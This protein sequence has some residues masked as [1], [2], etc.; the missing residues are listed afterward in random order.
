MS[1]IPKRLFIWLIAAVL[2][3]GIGNQTWGNGFAYHGISTQALLDGLRH[4]HS[5]NRA[6]AARTLGIRQEKAAV[7][8]LL[9]RL[10]DEQERDAVKH[11]VLDA[12]GRIADRRALLPIINVLQHAGSTDVRTAAALALGQFSDASA[13]Q[14]LLDA[15][16]T[17]RI[18]HVQVAVIHALGHIRHDQTVNALL[19][20]LWTSPN[21]TLRIVAVQSLGQLQSRNATQPLIAMLQQTPHPDLRREI[22][23]TFG[24]IGDPRAVKPL[25]VILQQAHNDSVLESIAIVALGRIGDPQAVDPLLRAFDSRDL[26]TRLRVVEA[27]GRIGHR[28]AIQPLVNRLRQ[29]LAATAS[30]T[31]ER[32]TQ[33]FAEH[34][35]LLHEQ[36]VIVQALGRFQDPRAAGGLRQAL[37]MRTFPQD[38]AEGLRLREGIY[39]RRRAAM[40]ALSQLQEVGAADT[41]VGLLRDQDRQIRAEAARLLGIHGDVRSVEPLIEALQDGEVDV[42]LEA[43]GT[44]GKLGASAAVEPLIGRLQD[45]H[46]LVREQAVQALA[47]LR[48]K[49]AIEPLQILQQRNTDARVERALAR[50]L[51]QIQ[52]WK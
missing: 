9:A 32:I 47:R 50:A 46:A 20:L 45:P 8:A 7:E 6:E 38:S 16:K 31:T 2:F 39:Q 33:T 10:Q 11:A 15:L 35:S 4:P 17:E 3:G 28:S 37:A 5:H 13:R 43:A 22:A 26:V 42:R 36:T 51:G 23:K 29:R 24:A 41:F 44:L 30:L 14:A 27:L 19:A 21:S 25:L 34:M 52:G 18:I 48:D 49:R 40:V 12:L 1:S